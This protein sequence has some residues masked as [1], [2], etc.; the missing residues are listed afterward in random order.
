V[1]HAVN[2]VAPSVEMSTGSAPP[3]VHQAPDLYRRS[4]LRVYD[5]ST[6]FSHK[7]RELTKLFS[8][9]LTFLPSPWPFFSDSDSDT[10]AVVSHDVSWVVAAHQNS[11]TSITESESRLYLSDLPTM[12]D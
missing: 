8:F 5:S 4:P 9:V 7:P 11:S 2:D 6:L 10:A 3:R 1:N 12:D